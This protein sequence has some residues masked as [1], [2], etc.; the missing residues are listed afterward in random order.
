MIT[1]Q[2]VCETVSVR[3]ADLQRWIGR[4]WV[5][6]LELAG[7]FRFE[8]IDVARV[9]LIVTLRDEMRVEEDT[10]PV[11]LSL[12][13]QLHDARREAAALRQLLRERGVT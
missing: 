11:V 10:L 12:L 13:D 3:P 2:A 1:L 8:D 4:A 5:R 7:E 6:P 9:R